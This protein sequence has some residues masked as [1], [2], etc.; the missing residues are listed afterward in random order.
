MHSWLGMLILLRFYRFPG[1]VLGHVWSIWARLW[2]QIGF[3]LE[4]LDPRMRGLGRIF[5]AKGKG[6]C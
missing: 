4:L 5:F 1:E 6:C 2:L 3:W